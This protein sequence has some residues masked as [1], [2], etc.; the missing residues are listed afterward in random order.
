M[1]AAELLRE[2]RARG[3]ALTWD[4]RQ[5][6]ATGPEAEVDA[7]LPK[8]RQEREALQD[9]LAGGS[10]RS[11]HEQLCRMVDEVVETAYGRGRLWQVFSHR[12]AVV[13]QPGKLTFMQ[14][15]DVHLRE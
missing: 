14:P 13:L 1:A 2:A 10:I 5:V 4:G 6:L 11:R 8:L 3:V 7:L 15:E 9:Y 12:V